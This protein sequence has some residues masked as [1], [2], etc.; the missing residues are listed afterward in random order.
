MRLAGEQL[1]RILFSCC[2]RAQV[3]LSKVWN[4]ECG[5]LCSFGRVFMVM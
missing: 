3:K 1:L 2:G 4:V 5:A